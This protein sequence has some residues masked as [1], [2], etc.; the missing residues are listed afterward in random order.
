MPLTENDRSLFKA[1]YEEMEAGTLK[2]P[3]LFDVAIKDAQR[4]DPRF[5]G[6]VRQEWAESKAQ[7]VMPVIDANAAVNAHN[8]GVMLTQV[9]GVVLAIWACTV[10]MR[11]SFRV[12]GRFSRDLADRLGGV[13]K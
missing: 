4:I 2:R 8:H 7:A 12:F 10:L 1:L 3:D 9:A 6:E 13:P 11:L 5:V